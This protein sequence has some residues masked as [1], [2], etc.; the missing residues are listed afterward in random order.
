LGYMPSKIAMVE[1]KKAT[2]KA[3]ELDEMLPEA[4]QLLAQSLAYEYDWRSAEHEFL[5]ALE[6]GPK[7][8][9]AL[10]GYASVCLLPTHRLDEAI[11]ANH[12]AERLDPLSSW[13]P[14]SRGICYY[15][16]RKWDSAIENCKRA[17]EIDPNAYAA[18][19]FLG[20]TLLEMG[21]VDEGI[22]ACEKAAKV[23]GQSQWALAIPGVAYAK[24]GRVEKAQRLLEELHVLSN[25]TYVSPSAFA[26]MY[27]NLGEIEKGIEW[28]EKAVDQHD[29]LIVASYLFP[30]YDPLRSHPR[31]KAL[32]RKMN[33]EP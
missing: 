2:L 31:Y 9:Y 20:F 7:S 8:V 6:L 16:A 15:V 13:L 26:W 12:R 4:H 28:F 11:A 21:K 10:N 29:M 23:V 27:C 19:Q 1:L 25:N 30:V 18:Y 3:L 5:R 32:L 22:A 17:L 14:W 24:A 33:L